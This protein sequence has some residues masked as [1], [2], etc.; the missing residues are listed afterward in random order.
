[1][2]FSIQYAEAP[3]AAPPSDPPGICRI[4]KRK[5]RFYFLLYI[6]E[7]ALQTQSIDLYQTEFPVKCQTALLV[8]ECYII[9]KLYIMTQIP[10][11]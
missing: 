4:S 6:S 9:S 8:D 10:L 11:L 1:M 3:L 5:E 7:S 2:N